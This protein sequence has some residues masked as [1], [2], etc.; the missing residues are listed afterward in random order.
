MI[1]NLLWVPILNHTG[2]H[3][4]LGIVSDVWPK[5]IHSSTKVVIYAANNLRSCHSWI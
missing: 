2:Q 5:P 4:L 1:E 3:C